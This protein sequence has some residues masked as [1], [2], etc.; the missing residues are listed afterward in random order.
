MRKL[1][2]S[3]VPT[4]GIHTL[5]SRSTSSSHSRTLFSSTAF[6]FL[7]RVCNRQYLDACHTRAVAAS[8]ALTAAESDA[9]GRV[10]T[11]VEAKLCAEI[12]FLSRI[13]DFR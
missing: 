3:S 4:E 13:S 10:E 8:A 2:E 9:S 6:P 1:G 7:P 11:S 5:A 12:L